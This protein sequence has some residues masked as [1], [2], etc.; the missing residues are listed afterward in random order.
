MIEY[1]PAV[2]IFFMFKLLPA[3]LMFSVSGVFT[4]KSIE[5][6]NVLVRE[7]GKKYYELI[8]IQVGL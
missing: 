3:T 5:C 1:L 2:L 7:K 6:C 8:E 4:K